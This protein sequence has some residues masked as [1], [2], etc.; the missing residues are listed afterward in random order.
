MIVKNSKVCRVTGWNE[1]HN[2]YDVICRNPGI[3]TNRINFKNER[4]SCVSHDQCTDNP[5]P[6]RRDHKGKHVL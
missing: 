5:L 2:V 1:L 6:Q 3:L 4:L